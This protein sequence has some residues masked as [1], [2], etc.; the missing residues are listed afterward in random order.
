MVRGHAKQVAQERNAKKAEAQRK[1][2]SGD[3]KKTKK[4]MLCKICFVSVIGEKAM[5][6]HYDGKH[7][8]QPFDPSAYTQ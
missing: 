7:P 4:A 1:K 5:K 8:S 6:A 2:G 3:D